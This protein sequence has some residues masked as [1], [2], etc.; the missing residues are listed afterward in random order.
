MGPCSSVCC[1][2]PFGSGPCRVEQVRDG[3]K[4]PVGRE[5]PWLR[6]PWDRAAP[7]F[8]GLAARPL[9]IPCVNRDPRPGRSVVA[10]RGLDG[11]YTWALQLL[12]AEPCSSTFFPSFPPSP[13]RRRRIHLRNS[14]PSQRSFAASCCRR[15]SSVRLS[16]RMYSRTTSGQRLRQR[17]RAQSRPRYVSPLSASRCPSTSRRTTRT[18]GATRRRSMRSSGSATK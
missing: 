15:S 17:P 7:G 8:S 1:Q 11:I 3:G 5:A 16:R 9:A 10:A 14:W 4:V 6:E 13:L 12:A 18:G 2:P